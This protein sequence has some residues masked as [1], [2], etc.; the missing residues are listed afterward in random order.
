VVADSFVEPQRSRRHHVGSVFWNVKRNLDVTLSRE[1][2]DL[3]G[4][5]ALQYLA[6]YRAIRKVAIVQ[7]QVGAALMRIVIDVVDALGVERAGSAK[8]TMHLIT[9][10]QQQFA[11]V[12]AVLASD[13]SD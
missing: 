1:I 11:E 9:L 2:V 3:V 4:L 10:A 5:H 12:G 8:D 6:Q 13:S 7:R